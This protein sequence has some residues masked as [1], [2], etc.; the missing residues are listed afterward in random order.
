MYFN[1]VGRGIL[2]ITHQGANPV[3]H[4][5]GNSISPGN[6]RFAHCNSSPF[7][8][9]I[10]NLCIFHTASTSSPGPLGPIQLTK[11]LKSGSAYRRRWFFFLKHFLLVF[12]YQ[13]LLL[14]IR[15]RVFLKFL[16]FLLEWLLAE[17]AVLN[18][19]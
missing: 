16:N 10:R 11:T 9:S 1:G 12:I 18:S 17:R 3:N 5:K 2:Y 15:K 8:G 14:N 4:V 7:R 19:H 6:C 13:F